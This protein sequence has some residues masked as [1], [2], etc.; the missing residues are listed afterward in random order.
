MGGTMTSSPSARGYGQLH[1]Q[2]VL[3][4]PM[5]SPYPYYNL[6]HQLQYHRPPHHPPLGLPSWP[7]YPP[8]VHPPMYYPMQF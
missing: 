3:Q 8:G 4:N 2:P 5:Y 7:Q 6:N 1:M